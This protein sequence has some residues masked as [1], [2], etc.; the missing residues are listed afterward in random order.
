MERDTETT[1]VAEDRLGVG[2]VETSENDP[3]RID[4]VDA[5]TC[6]GRIG[7]TL[8][9]GRRASGPFIGVWAR[10]LGTDLDAIRDWG[11]TALVSLVEAE[12]F[13]WCG[14]PDLPEQACARGLRHLHLPIVDMSIP[15]EGFE[16]AWREHGPELQRM[17][18][19]GRSVVLHCLAGLGRTGTIAARLLVELGAT[20]DDAIER[21][22]LARP[23]TIQTLMQELY[24]R[25]LPAASA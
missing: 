13:E 16:A 1:D 8:C 10:D 14:I 11:A 5:G 9:P 22:R 7:M 2:Y 24:V 17:L 15:E 4:W 18:R 6:G 25:S 3:L 20:P 21:V 12:E 23:G 19:E